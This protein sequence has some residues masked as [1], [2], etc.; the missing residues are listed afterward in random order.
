MAASFL[1]LVYSLWTDN[2]GLRLA[3]FAFAAGL[4]SAV[5][6]VWSSSSAKRR[7]W[8]PVLEAELKKWQRERPSELRV[9]LGRP[10][11]YEAAGGLQIEAQIVEETPQFIHVLLSVD[12][13]SLPASLL[14]LSANFFCEL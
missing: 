10:V 2:G 11:C 12:D 1:Q 8:Q 13:G 14:P 6:G 4:A 5:A 9:A 3:F 7:Q